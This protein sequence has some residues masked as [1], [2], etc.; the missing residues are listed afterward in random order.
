MFCNYIGFL[1][2]QC[3]LL[4]L[5]PLSYLSLIFLLF[6]GQRCPA[7]ALRCVNS[8]WRMQNTTPAS[9][10]DSLYWP[11]AAAGLAT[12]Y[13]ITINREQ[14]TTIMSVDR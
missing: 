8:R 11:R 12:K 10:S 13:M 3:L 9:A 1:V 7:S 14:F 2:I 6:G 5:L 4:L